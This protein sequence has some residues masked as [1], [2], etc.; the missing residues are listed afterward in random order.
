M[1]IDEKQ[2]YN[3]LTVRITSCPLAHEGHPR[4]I[5]Y[6]LAHKAC[7][8]LC[9]SARFEYAFERPV[10]APRARACRYLRRVKRPP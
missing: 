8:D 9:V 2:P 1:D 10:L 3:A 7:R 4:P 6:E 5:P